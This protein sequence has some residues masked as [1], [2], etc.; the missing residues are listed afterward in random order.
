MADKA[1]RDSFMYIFGLLIVLGIIVF[2]ISQ[3]GN[4]G[5]LFW[6][7]PV[8]KT[9]A[10][11]PEKVIVDEKAYQALIKTNLGDI[12]V[13]LFADNAPTTVNN[14]VFLSRD[15]F[16][17]GVQFHRIVRDFIAQTGSRL[18]L[19]KNPQNDGVGGPGYRFEDEMNW[20]SLGLSASQ[21][22]SLKTSGYASSDK[23]KSVLMDKYYLAM[24]N[25]G[26]N[27]NGSQFFFTLADKANESIDSLQGRHTVFGKVI[28]GTE[29]LDAM[30]R[31][32][33]ADEQTSSPRPISPI[34]INSIEIIEL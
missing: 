18:S 9:Y 21:R 11:A 5:L 19:D 25:A 22:E 8:E 20:D 30:N 15:K 2:V 7:N 16:Y 28:E 31:V 6:G 23:V 13:E 26:P 33:L 14:F 10:K 1:T 17:D 32:E 4:L 3:L 27:T 34:T 29:V 24:A 12:K